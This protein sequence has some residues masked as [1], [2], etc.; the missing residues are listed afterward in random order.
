MEG[1]AI[2]WW[3]WFFFG[4]VLLLA[5]FVTP[6]A[7]YQLFFGVGALVVAVIGMTGLRLPLAVELGT[8]LA[9][10]IGTILVLR[11][12]LLEKLGSTTSAKVD[13]LEGE[14]ALAMEKIAVD[15]TGKAE[16]RGAVWSARNVGWTDIAKS[17]RCR[18]MSTEGLTLCVSGLGTPETEAGE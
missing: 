15:A 5:E 14:T 12:P 13:R 6:G 16:L 4:I 9:V 10:S 2:E 3:M 17:E 7:F 18:V 8:F 1:F 11:K